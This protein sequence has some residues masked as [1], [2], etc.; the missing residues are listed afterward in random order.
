[1]EKSELMR[2]LK[3]ARVEDIQELMRAL[4]DRYRE[5]YPDWE[6]F[7][8]SLECCDPKLRKKRFAQI[9]EIAYRYGM[10]WDNNMP[11]G[12]EENCSLL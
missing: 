3:E 2:R 1:M 11:E 5:L 7:V 10:E 8:F 12:T 6:I 4:H 9:M